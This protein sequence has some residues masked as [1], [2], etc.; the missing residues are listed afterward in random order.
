MHLGRVSYLTSQDQLADTVKN[1]NRGLG[2]AFDVEIF[3][4]S[5]SETLKLDSLNSR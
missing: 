1:L 3:V 2:I 4:Q 5:N